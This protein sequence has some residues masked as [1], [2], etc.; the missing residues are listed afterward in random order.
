MRLEIIFLA[1]QMVSEHCGCDSHPTPLKLKPQCF[2]C[3]RSLIWNGIG[4]GVDGK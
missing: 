4:L 3:S 1:V 2:K